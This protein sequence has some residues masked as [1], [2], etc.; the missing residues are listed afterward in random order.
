MAPQLYALSLGTG[1]A[2]LFTWGPDGPLFMGRP[3]LE[4]EYNPTLGSKGDIILAD[5]HEYFLAD[6]EDMTVEISRDV[7]FVNDETAFRFRMRVDGLPA[8]DSP[9]T[10]LNGTATVSPFVSLAERA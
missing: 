7:R 10:P 5:L 1:A 8:W 9:T 2:P 3:V 6:P 4:T